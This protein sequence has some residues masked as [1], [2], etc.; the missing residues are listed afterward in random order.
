M[1]DKF[2]CVQN[3]FNIPTLRDFQKRALAHL[4]EKEHVFVCA[5]TGG[6]KSMCYQGFAVPGF[7]DGKIVIVFSSPS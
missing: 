1:E 7:T 4:V 2:T 6:G 3:F 5:A